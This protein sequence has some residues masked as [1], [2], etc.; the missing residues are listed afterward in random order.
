MNKQ[1]LLLML[2]SYFLNLKKNHQRGFTVIESLTAISI[3]GITFSIN[4]QFL[5]FL[6]IQNLKQEI[7]TGAVA[8][9]KEILDDVRYQLKDS[10]SNLT[11]GQ[12]QLTDQTSLGYIYD[13]DIYVCSD[14]PS[15]DAQNQVTN[16]PTSI[17]EVD[18]RH[19]VVQVIDKKRN[20]EKVYTVETA[21]TKLQ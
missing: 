20:N 12:T 14:K 1:H 8:L 3:L 10:T 9:S 19:I 16:C 13:A 5:I 7:K 4:L 15:I 6:K 11:L 2:T 21:F 17:G 18:I